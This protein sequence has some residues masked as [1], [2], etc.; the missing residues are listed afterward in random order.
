[1]KD[2]E[3][4]T[5]QNAC[6]IEKFSYKTGEKVE[7]LFDGSRFSE[8]KAFDSYQFSESEDK[9]LV[10]TDHEKDLSSLLFCKLS[11]L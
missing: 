7:T 9:I 1:M 6:L 2:G 3:H 8:T 5:I 11:R 4:Y 10:E